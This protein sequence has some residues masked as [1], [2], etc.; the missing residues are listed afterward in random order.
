MGS[1]WGSLMQK[2]KEG[3]T[4]LRLIYINVGVFLMLR[5]LLF[6]FRIFH[7]E[8]GEAVLQ[9]LQMPSGW[10]QIGIRPWT[11]FTYMFVHLDLLHILFNMLWL[12]FFGG[13]FSRW[14]NPRQLVSLYVLGGL[15]GGLFFA[16][17]FH[18]LSEESLHSTVYLVGASASV[19]AL[20]VAAASYRPDEP[21]HLF[22]LGLLK[23]KYLAIAMMVMDF[24]SLTGEN[25][26]GSLA[27]IGGALTGLVFGVTWRQGKDLTAWVNPIID[28]LSFHKRNAPRR[29]MKITYKRSRYEQTH[30]TGDID[31]AY[32]DRKKSDAEQMDAILDKIKQSGYDSLTKQEK[33][34]LFDF[35]RH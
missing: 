19:L 5:L 34:Q 16:L 30:K 13:L 25:A 17:F 14:F 6:F 21:I 27:H 20:G 22:L 8:A 29:K 11:L 1:F 24:L 4:V 3:T 15:F 31:Q 33:K 18:F 2:Y 10:A 28:R 12:F 26:G 32:R 7:M 35:S 23:L 9:N